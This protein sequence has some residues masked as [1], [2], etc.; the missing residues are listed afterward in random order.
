MDGEF[1]E[2]TAAN[3]NDYKGLAKKYLKALGGTDN[4]IFIDNCVTRLRLQIEDPELVNEEAL[5]NAGAKGIIRLSES[6]LQVVVG[7]DVEF[8]A[9]ELKK[10]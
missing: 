8:L 1:T 10:L 9:D 7:T 3:T 2:S 4:L 6:D 5:K